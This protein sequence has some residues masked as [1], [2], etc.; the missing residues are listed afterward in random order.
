MGRSVNDRRP[1]TFI[2]ELIRIAGGENISGDAGME[3][4]EFSLE[5]VLERDPEV[6]I[7]VWR[8]ADDV[9]ARPAWNM[10]L[11]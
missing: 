9:R 6:I 4:P 1:G 10:Y 5:V 11:L 3:W 8:D 2:D 7:T